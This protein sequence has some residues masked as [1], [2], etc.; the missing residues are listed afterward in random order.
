[1]CVGKTASSGKDEKPKSNVEPREQAFESCA[2]IGN[3]TVYR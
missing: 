2:D 3:R 1:M